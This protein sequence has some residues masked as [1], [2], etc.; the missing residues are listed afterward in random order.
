MNEWTHKQMNEWM[1]EHRNVWTHKLE[2]ASLFSSML[3][4][5]ESFFIT[6]ASKAQKINI[7]LKS[8]KNKFTQLTKKFSHSILFYSIYSIL[9]SKSS[10]SQW[11]HK[12]SFGIMFLIAQ[13]G[14][15]V[16]VHGISENTT[17]EYY[18]RIHPQFCDC[19]MFLPAD[20]FCHF[21]L[22]SKRVGWTSSA[23]RERS[24]HPTS[25]FS[26]RVTLSVFGSSLPVTT[27]RY[28]SKQTLLFTVWLHP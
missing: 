2:Q 16:Y 8:S 28:N 26:M 14:D 13:M 3:T 11:G 6:P 7:Y 20:I 23:L 24:H 17:R 1:S 15:H 22:Q 10:E 19:Q 12:M 9:Y 21:V 27:I 25:P 18:S 4:S 5:K